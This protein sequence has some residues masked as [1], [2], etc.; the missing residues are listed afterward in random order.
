MLYATPLPNEVEKVLKLIEGISSC[1]KGGIR[2]LE[3]F[4]HLN[5]DYTPPLHKDAL[6][7][8][9][10][11][12][13]QHVEFKSC[14]LSS[15]TIRRYDKNNMDKQRITSVVAFLNSNGGNLFI[16]V[17]D[18][19]SIHGI[20]EELE[21]YHNSSEDKFVMQLTSL[22]RDKISMRA[23]NDDQSKTISKPSELLSTTL[24]P[25]YGH[26]VAW[27]KI[28]PSKDYLFFYQEKVGREHFYIRSGRNKQRVKP[29]DIEYYL[30]LQ[31]A[32]R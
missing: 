7:I 29:D 17:D 22:F 21:H 28:K 24:V 20:E 14:Y 2:Y 5:L 10:S 16:G 3:K 32:V 26:T 19:L 9:R 18:D 4:Q 27:V 12:E 15:N 1:P 6:E 23:I 8:I 31:R 25:I 30:A 11:D 13:G